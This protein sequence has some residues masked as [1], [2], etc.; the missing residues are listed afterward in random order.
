[1]PL[2]TLKNPPTFRTDL[3]ATKSGWVDSVTGEVLVAIRQLKTKRRNL[4]DS[5]L[6]QLIVDEV[7]DQ[8]AFL[9]ISPDDGDRPFYLVL[10]V[11]I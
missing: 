7:N 1:M 11:E 10:N 8:N 3:I 4:I 9:L 2:W 6:C 5:E